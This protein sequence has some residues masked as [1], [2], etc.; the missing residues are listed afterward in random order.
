MVININVVHMKRHRKE[1]MVLNKSYYFINKPEVNAYISTF[2]YDVDRRRKMIHPRSPTK[3]LDT[4]ATH[5]AAASPSFYSQS[6]ALP[7]FHTRFSFVIVLFIVVCCMR[8][9]LVFSESP[10]KT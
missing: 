3:I 5:A 7:I 6:N 4:A 2:I 9:Q 10:Q 8:W 1:Q